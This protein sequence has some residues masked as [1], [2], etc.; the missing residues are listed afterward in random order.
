MSHKTKNLFHQRKK[1]EPITYDGN[2]EPIPFPLGSREGPN[3]LTLKIT[4]SPEDWQT[5]F[6]LAEAD[7]EHLGK[8]IK[9][10]ITNPIYEHYLTKEEIN[11]TRGVHDIAE[12]NFMD[13]ARRYAVATYTVLSQWAKGPMASWPEY[14]QALIREAEK[15]MGK[16]NVWPPEKEAPDVITMVRCLIALKYGNQIK[17]FRL[18]EPE[19]M[20]NEVFRKTYLDKNKLK[21][22]KFYIQEYGDKMTVEWLFDILPEF[23]WVAE[24]E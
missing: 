24:D 17:Q 7:P 12:R 8:L 14:L 1:G 5:L 11:Q 22:A 16:E 2:I 9:F 3:A 15:T 13:R 6:L 4:A 23:P 21:A 18:T 10:Y 19:F 20:D